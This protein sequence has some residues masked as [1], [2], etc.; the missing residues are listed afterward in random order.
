MMRMILCIAVV[1]EEVVVLS[2]QEQ[3]YKHVDNNDDE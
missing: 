1:D 2:I 3:K